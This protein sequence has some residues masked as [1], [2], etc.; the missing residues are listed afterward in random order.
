MKLRG[1]TSK[2]Q[3]WLALALIAVVL[4]GVTVWAFARLEPPPEEVSATPPPVLDSP[5]DAWQF[6]RTLQGT[7]I[8]DELPLVDV[9]WSEIEER[10]GYDHLRESPDGRW[11]AASRDRE[12]GRGWDLAV[13]DAETGDEVMR[14][15]RMRL[16]HDISLI[17]WSADS[18]YFLAQDWEEE[19]DGPLMIVLD[20]K[21]RSISPVP[22]KLDGTNVPPPEWRWD[23]E[24]TALLGVAQL[25]TETWERATYRLYH[26]DLGTGRVSR[27]SEFEFPPYCDVHWSPDRELIGLNPS[28][29]SNKGGPLAVALVHSGRIL[30]PNDLSHIISGEYESYH[31][32][33]KDRHW[34]AWGCWGHQPGVIYAWGANTYAQWDGT[35]WRVNAYEHT[36][37]MIADLRE[38]LYERDY[39][40]AF[41]HMRPGREELSI[42]VHNMVWSRED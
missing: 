30:Y 6:E 34:R 22:V 35:I 2:Q 4:I 29:S 11:H 5:V 3:I 24:G 17:G 18:H 1:L 27:K 31:L 23:S 15:G 12:G 9:R 21:K 16:A 13:L 37:E 8:P 41:L 33:A 32:T 19:E 7:R 28:F 20:M 14:Y 25:D 38:W 42:Q 40:S 26:F 10:D 39:R 36:E